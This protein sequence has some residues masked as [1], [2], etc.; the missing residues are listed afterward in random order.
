MNLIEKSDL[1]V[2]RAMEVLSAS[3]VSEVW[4]AAGAEVRLVGSVRMGL[5]A[6]HRDIDI[7]VYSSGITEEKSFAVMSQIAK[8]PDITE[9]KCI[10]GLH[11]E[12]RCIAWHL[13]YRA[14]ENEVWQLDVIHIESGSAYDGYFEQMADRIKARL[15]DELRNL[16]LELKFNTPDDEDIHGV[17]YYEAVLSDGVRSLPELR[18]WLKTRRARPFYYWMPD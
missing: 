10:N 15:T 2:K 6:K 8:N 13:K 3:G 4:D 7:H 12:E 17:E 1:A 9:I 11:T 5:L 16:I 14:A 18:E